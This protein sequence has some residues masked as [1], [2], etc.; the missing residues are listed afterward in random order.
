MKKTT[1]Y[2]RIEAGLIF[3]A[4]LYIY[5]YLHFNLLLFVVLL[6][7]VDVFM[8]GYVTKNNATGALVY[9]LGHSFI[10][11]AL[12]I[13]LGLMTGSDLLIG[14]SIIWVAHIGFDR[15]LGYGLKLDSGF[16]DTHL[17]KIGKN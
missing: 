16:N 10:I 7:V 13:V 1:L 12:V 17:G 2:L 11:P 15:A 8:I 3:V 14:G 4:C 6:L 5:H 9:N